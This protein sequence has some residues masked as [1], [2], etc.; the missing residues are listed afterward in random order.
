MAERDKKFI[1]GFVKGKSLHLIKS[2]QGERGNGIDTVTV[3]ESAADSG[4]N[5]ITITFTDGVSKSFQVKNGTGITHIEQTVEA[6]VD[7]QYNVITVYLSNDTSFTFR[8]R[9]GSKGDQGIQGTSA[10][11]N[12]N[13]EVLTE[14]EHE[15]GTATN[16][17]MS[18]NAITEFVNGRFVKVDSEDAMEA[19]IDAGPNTENGYDPDVFYYTEEE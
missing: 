9:N 2:I 18:Q 14:L 4:Y 1:L 11:W 19:M 8:V 16:R 7:E 5:N 3:N 17:T 13:A 6:E 15:P 12:A 10:I